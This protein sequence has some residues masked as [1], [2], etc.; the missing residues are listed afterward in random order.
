VTPRDLVASLGPKLFLKVVPRRC[1]TTGFSRGGLQGGIAGGVSRFPTGMVPMG[2]FP[3]GLHKEVFRWGVPTCVGSFVPYGRPHRCPAMDVTKGTPP[4]WVQQAR[5]L[6][7]V[8][9]GV[10]HKWGH[11]MIF[12]RGSP[13]WCPNAGSLS[14]PRLSLGGPRGWYHWRPQGVSPCG[15]PQERS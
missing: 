4:I 10:S 15:V 14:D 8:L 13:K 2:E 5:P 11:P 7:A 3:G 6:F 9:Q 1:S 12:T